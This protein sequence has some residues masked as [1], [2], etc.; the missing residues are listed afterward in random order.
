MMDN[1]NNKHYLLARD[2]LHLLEH[3]LN[4]RIQLLC[5]LPSINQTTK[6]VGVSLSIFAI[7]YDLYFSGQSINQFQ[8]EQQLH[9]VLSFLISTIYPY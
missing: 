1:L 8:Q 9:L 4:E 7:N 2:I 3:G 5:P 6:T